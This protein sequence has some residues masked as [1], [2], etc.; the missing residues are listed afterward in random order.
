[1]AAAVVLSGE[2][3]EQDL[4]AYCRG[5]LAAFKVPRRLHIVDEIPRTA[6]GKV[7]RRKVAEAIG[8]DR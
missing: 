5:Q 8:A 3:S 4:L 6:T 1:V 2:A 7:Q